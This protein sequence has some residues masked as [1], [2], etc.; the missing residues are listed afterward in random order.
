MTGGEPEFEEDLADTND[1]VEA[2]LSELTD[3]KA[4]TLKPEELRD[5]KAAQYALRNMS[6]DHANNHDVGELY[7]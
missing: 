5:F 7:E 3:V 6:E 4:Y 1:A 2:A